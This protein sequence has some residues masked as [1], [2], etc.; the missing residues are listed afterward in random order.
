MKDN[1]TIDLIRVLNILAFVFSTLNMVF[2]VFVEGRSNG[3]L[4]IW[5]SLALFCGFMLQKKYPIFKKLTP[6]F[7]L[8]PLLWL[9]AID[10]VAFILILTAI[11]TYFLNRGLVLSSYG[12]LVDEFKKGTMV[13][14]VILLLSYIA[15]D[16]IS[17]NNLA[18]PFVLI[19]LITSVILLRS[20]RYLE[21][22]ND[23]A[24]LNRSNIRYAA[25][26]V[27]TSL[28][29]SNNWALTQLKNVLRFIK[30]IYDWILIVAFSWL[31]DLIGLLAEKIYNFILYLLE[32]YG[33][34]V[35]V[36]QEE[37][38]GEAYSDIEKIIN[39]DY[40]AYINN[41]KYLSIIL[42]GLTLILFCYLIFRLYAKQANKK[43]VVED[44]IEKKEFILDNQG[45][46]QIFNRVINYVRPKS[47]EEKVRIYYKKFLENCKINN[48]SIIRS[49]TSMDVALKAKSQYDYSLME[50]M[51]RIY[52][53][54]RYGEERVDSKT[55]NT[56]KGYYKELVKDK[57]IK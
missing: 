18:A 7:M 52:I 40:E 28:I 49:D 21:Y 1:Y 39:I 56:F 2:L 16:F 27:L 47:N 20:L 19:Y 30:S 42:G 34:E 5:F 57:T 51:R 3:F 26:A 32:K 17:F 44:Y 55:L 48:I 33:G 38:V 15:N 22:S 12:Y 36:P 43:V 46:K 14:G 29:L 50:E 11:S 37:I 8:I 6:I 31:F 54:V 25:I 24:K 13:I 9:R 35:D 4:F 41:Q 45:F 10:E 53:A 23:V